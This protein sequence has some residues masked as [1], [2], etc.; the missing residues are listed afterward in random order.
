MSQQFFINEF[1]ASY[2]PQP[3]SVAAE[4][5]AKAHNQQLTKPQGALGQLEAIVLTLAKQ[6]NTAKPAIKQPWISIFAADHG[7]VAEGVSAYP[8][9]VTRQMLVNFVQGGAAISVLARQQQ[10]QLEVIDCGMVESEPALSGVL[11]QPIAQ[12]TANLLQQAAMT[13]AQCQQALTIGRQA[14]L[15]AQASGADLLI[16]GEMGIGNTTSAAALA[17]AALDLP[18]VQLV[19]AGTGLDAAGVQHK[20]GVIEQAIARA[21][22]QQ[23]SSAAEQA[24][25]WLTQVGGFEIAAMTGAYLSC[26]EQGISALVDGFISSVAALYAVR[27]SPAARE[28]MLF[29]HQSAEPGHQLVLQALQAKP[30]LQLGMRL[31]EASGAAV[32][33]GLLRTACLL[34]GEMATFS[35]AAV[36]QQLAASDGAVCNS[37][38]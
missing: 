3:L 19:G 37:V 11:H 35:Q 2:R 7:V 12:G 31:G 10:A 8:Q 33:L 38:S 30:L 4:A 27:I 20:Q 29:S 15:R 28:W 32:A 34:H 13:S 25:Y 36:D 24:E 6:Q 9:S 1:L 21:I 5:A 23:P 16:A 17:V 18:A 26:A 14:V 22:S